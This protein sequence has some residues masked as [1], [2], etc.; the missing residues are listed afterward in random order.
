MSDDD[1]LILLYGT[2]FST[3]MESLI[4]ERKDGSKIWNF[5]GTNMPERTASTYINLTFLVQ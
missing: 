3:K 5:N 2:Y 1:Q 4:L